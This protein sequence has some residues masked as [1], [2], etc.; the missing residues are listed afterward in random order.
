MVLCLHFVPSLH[1]EKREV[2][3]REWIGGA[4]LLGAMSLFDRGLDVAHAVM[5]HG[6]RQPRI[7]EVGRVTDK[8]RKFAQRGGVIAPGVIE[9]GLVVAFLSGH[10]VFDREGYGM[11]HGGL[12]RG[13]LRRMRIRLISTDFDGTLHA[14]TEDPPVPEDLQVLLADLQAAGASWVINTGRDLSGLLEAVGRARLRVRPDFVVVVERAIYQRQGSA[15]VAVEP[16]NGQCERMHLE[17]FQR[18]TP[19]LPALKAWVQAR[20]RAL[21]Y[22]DNFSPFCVIATSNGEMDAIQEHLAEYCRSVPGLDVMRND[23]YSR[24]NHADFNK[25]TALREVARILGVKAEETVAAGDHW[26]DLPMLSWSLAHGLIA[27]ANAIEP[28]KAAVQRQGGYVSGQP[29]GHGVARGL[30]RLLG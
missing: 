3:V 4:K 26:N 24:F 29:W 2:G 1:V 9:H 28:V 20:F 10:N 5:A 7:V 16:W 27:P 12:Q 11:I 8:G 22:E 21:I 6:Q 18:I 14:E 30:E 19:D 25:G 17:L 15:Y 23:V 13:T